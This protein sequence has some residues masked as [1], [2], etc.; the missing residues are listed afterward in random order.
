MIA[1]VTRRKPGRQ[2]RLGLALLRLVSAEPGS[3]YPELAKRLQVT[4]QAVR[5]VVCLYEQAGLVQVQQTRGALCVRL[6]PAGAVL[7]G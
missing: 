3:T 1:P 5:K 4:V 2:N 6:S 7:H